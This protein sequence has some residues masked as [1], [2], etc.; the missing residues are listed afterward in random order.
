ML[1]S[2]PSWDITSSLGLMCIGWA[3]TVWFKLLQ[4]N[5]SPGQGCALGFQRHLGNKRS[6]IPRRTSPCW[7]LAG[8]A[9]LDNSIQ[10]VLRSQRASE[11]NFCDEA[12]LVRKL[13]SWAG[14]VIALEFGEESF[15]LN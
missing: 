10:S 9:A 2:S 8:N 1:F 3:G 13:I 11:R 6:Q 15:C 5:E 12:C 7:P 4:C 14:K